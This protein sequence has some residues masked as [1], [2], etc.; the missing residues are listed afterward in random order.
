[1]VEPRDVRNLQR[2]AF[3]ESIN[4]MLMKAAGQIKRY[5]EPEIVP[6]DNAIQYEYEPVY[7]AKNIKID[8]KV[9]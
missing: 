7:P 4:L 9:E 6:D 5:T 1:M 8:F 2:F 3:R